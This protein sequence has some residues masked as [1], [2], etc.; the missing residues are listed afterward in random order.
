MAKNKIIHFIGK[1]QRNDKQVLQRLFDCVYRQ[2]R[3]GLMSAYTE[4]FIG[5]YFRKLVGSTAIEISN[6]FDI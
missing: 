2:I 5:F 6:D 4:L 1:P 3:F